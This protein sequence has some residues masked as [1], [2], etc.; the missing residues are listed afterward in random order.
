MNNNGQSFATKSANMQVKTPQSYPRSSKKP[1]KLHERRK[2]KCTAFTQGIRTISLSRSV[3][4]AL[5]QLP[6]VQIGKRTILFAFV[7]FLQV[8]KYVVQVPFSRRSHGIIKSN[9]FLLH[10]RNCANPMHASL[11]DG[12]KYFVQCKQIFSW[13]FFRPAF[14][15]IVCKLALG[16]SSNGKKS[17][18]IYSSDQTVERK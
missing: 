18:N 1:N 16:I 5:N 2:A 7:V 17:G 4:S 11:I 10:E 9:L 6:F 8:P 3:R 12:K 13:N 14:D 15:I